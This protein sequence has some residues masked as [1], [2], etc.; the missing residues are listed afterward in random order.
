MT[1]MDPQVFIRLSIDSLGLRIR[2]TALSSSRAGIRTFSAPCAC[3]IRIRGFPV[4][5]IDFQLRIQSRQGSAG[6]FIEH[7]SGSGDNLDIETGRRER[8]GWKVKIHDLSGS[9]VAAAFITT[10]FV[11]STGYDW[12][13]KSNPRAW[14]IL[15]PDALRPESWLLWGKLK[16]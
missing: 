13:A 4:Q 1:T 11:P 8:K 16:H 5:T 10:P 12:V 6:L 9:A 3:E 7:L 14:L 15:R 2:E